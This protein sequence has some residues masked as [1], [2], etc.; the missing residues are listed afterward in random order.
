MGKA[1]GKAS[2]K[3]KG[4]LPKVN[5]TTKP[6]TTKKVKIHVKGGVSAPKVKAS[7]KIKIKLSAKS[8]GF[9]WKANKDFDN[10]VAPSEF[11]KGQKCQPAFMTA[12]QQ[13]YNVNWMRKQTQDYGNKCFLALVPLRVKL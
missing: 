9:T 4:K 12:Y 2:L 3:I 6:K 7:H 11:L 5:V 10:K 8:T 1:T 13:L